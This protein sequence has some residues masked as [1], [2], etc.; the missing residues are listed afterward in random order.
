KCGGELVDRP[1]RYHRLTVAIV[2]EKGGAKQRNQEEVL[3]LE[4]GLRLI[5]YESDQ[6]L[7]D[8]EWKLK[9][10]ISVTKCVS[11]AW[12]SDGYGGTSDRGGR[13]LS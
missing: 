3:A 13:R 12:Q 5:V 4:G 8:S 1:R 7:C 6:F 11:H 10:K 9:C 2:T